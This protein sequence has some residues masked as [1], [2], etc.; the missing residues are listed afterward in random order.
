MPSENRLFLW[1]EE[2][3]R[4]EIKRHRTNHSVQLH[5]I[6][7]ANDKEQREGNVVP[8]GRQQGE[9]SSSRTRRRSRKRRIKATHPHGIEHSIEQ[10]LH[11]VPN[12]S[13]PDISSLLQSSALEYTRPG[14]LNQLRS[15]SIVIKIIIFKKHSCRMWEVSMTSEK[16]RKL[17]NSWV[18]ALNEV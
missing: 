6:S 3:Q 14:C 10:S 13:V 18:R 16:P 11:C 17:C 12:E 5:D 4:R 7:V 15:S 1:G 8:E 2:T 9:F